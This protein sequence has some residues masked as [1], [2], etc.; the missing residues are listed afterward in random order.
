MKCDRTVNDH[1]PK[2][3]GIKAAQRDWAA[4]E[5]FASSKLAPKIVTAK[6]EPKSSPKDTTDE[7]ILWYA[8]MRSYGSEITMREALLAIL[9]IRIVETYRREQAEAAQTVRNDV[10][11]HDDVESSEVVQNVSSH[12]PNHEIA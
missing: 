5:P 10:R 12:M 4:E 6:P 7:F 8:K 9:P 11:R 1:V 2:H 3:R